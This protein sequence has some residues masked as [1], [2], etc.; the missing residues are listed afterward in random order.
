MEEPP[1]AALQR[2][3][4]RKLG[5]CLIRIQQYELLL[6]EMVAK[7]EVT[8]ELGVDAFRFADDTSN[9][10]LGTLVGELTKSYFKPTLLESVRTQSE[11]EVGEKERPAGWMSFSMSVAMPPDAHSQLKAELQALVDLRNDLVHHFVEGQDLLSEE[12]CIA[13]DIYLQ[14]CYTEIDRHFASLCGWANSM[15]EAKLS[16][17]GFVTSQEY[18]EFLRAELSSPPSEPNAGLAGLVDLLVRAEETLGIG[19]WTS[20]DAAIA[21]IRDAAPGVGPRSH[22]FRNWRQVLRESAAFEVRRGPSKSAGRMET[23]YRSRQGSL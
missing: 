19:G 12:G 7:R 2:E 1:Y 13:A 23:R 15:N 22:S 14:D 5:R 6:K 11:P 17:A 9:K 16:L 10:T 3:V 8:G 4:Q 21:H 18:M 20:L